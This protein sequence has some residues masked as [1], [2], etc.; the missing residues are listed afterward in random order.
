MVRFDMCTH[1]HAHVEHAGPPALDAPHRGRQM[2]RAATF[3][4]RVK[5]TGPRR[6]PIVIRRFSV[7]SRRPLSCRRRC[8]LAGSL[9]FIHPRGLFFDHSALVL[10]R[11]DVVMVS[12]GSP[13]AGGAFFLGRRRCPV[14]GSLF[15]VAS[16][17]CPAA[18]SLHFMNPRCRPVA[19]SVF[20]VFQR[21]CLLTGSVFYFF[22]RRCPSQGSLFSSKTG[23]CPVA[24]SLTALNPRRFV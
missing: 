21:G 18:G 13:R 3:V 6:T 1:Y 15:F 22:Q 10:E 2:K 16:R 17:G 8:P 19:G 14:A 9:F 7:G 12:T 23:R 4:G 11:G 20:D 24:G 5:A